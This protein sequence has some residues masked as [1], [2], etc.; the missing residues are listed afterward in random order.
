MDSLPLSP[1]RCFLAEINVREKRY[2][3]SEGD[4]EALVRRFPHSRFIKWTQV[5]LFES[6]KVYRE[7]GDIYQALADAYDEIPQAQKNAF[8]TR[9]CEAHMYYLAGEKE[10]A[11]SACDK[12]LSRKQTLQGDYCQ[13][14]YRDTEKLLKKVSR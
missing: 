1:H 5:K 2:D 10:L 12:I 7:A 3:E 6:T 13:K 4:I 8:F 11:K 14:L 9:N